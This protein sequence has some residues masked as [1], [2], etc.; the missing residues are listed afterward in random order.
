[1]NGIAWRSAASAASRS[2]GWPMTLT[3]TFAWR[4]SGVVSTDGDRGE[5]DPRI[6]D[7]PRDDLADL[8]PRSELVA[9]AVAS[10]GVIEGSS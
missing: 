7:L 9:L 5:P 3:Q 4:R 2:A 6:R 10:A 1:M 8:L